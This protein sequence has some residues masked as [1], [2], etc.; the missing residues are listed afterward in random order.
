ME[1]KQNIF[2]SSPWRA[3]AGLCIPSLISI[4]VLMLYNMADVSKGFTA[5][6]RAGF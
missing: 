2:E 4:V 5:E 3:I 1:Q 6:Q